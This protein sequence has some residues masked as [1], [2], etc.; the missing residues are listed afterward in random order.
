MSTQ[1]SNIN[2]VNYIWIAALIFSAS[3]RYTC[4]FTSQHANAYMT[5]PAQ[6]ITNL[7][8]ATEVEEEAPPRSVGLA[9]QLDDGTRKS[10]SMAENTAFVTG[11][12]KGMSNRSSFASLV[13]SLYHV[14]NAMEEAFDVTTDDRVKALDKPELRR[15]ESLRKDMEFYYTD[16]NKIAPPTAATMA[17]VNRVKEVAKSDPYLLVAHQYTRYLGDLFGGQM[18]G[19]MATRSLNLEPGQGIKFYEFDGISNNKVFIEDWYRDLN[20]LDFTEEQKQA[21]VDE[22]N[23]VFT[24]NI[25]IFEELDGSPF[26]AMFAIFISTLKSKLGMSPALVE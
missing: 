15:V 22:A 13:T 3:A 9:L 23:L 21:I 6:K 8:A 2:S 26:K 18:M 19:G 25:G 11:F 17:Y 14:Y 16:D 7:N 20:A 1:K 12:F 5:L 24:L 4:A 10:H